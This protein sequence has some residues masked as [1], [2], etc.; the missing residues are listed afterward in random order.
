[1]NYD[2]YQ[3]LYKNGEKV[4]TDYKH[5]YEVY[6]KKTLRIDTLFILKVI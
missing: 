4:F 2:F 3:I 1:M 6:L 5:T